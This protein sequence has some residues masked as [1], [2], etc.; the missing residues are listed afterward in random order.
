MDKSLKTWMLSQAS[1][2]LEYQQPRKSI[3]LLEALMSIDKKNPD[4]YR[5]LSYAYLKVERPEESIR[6]ADNFLKYARP[7]GDIR[8][9]KWIKGRALLKKR[10]AALSR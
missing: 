6:A 4:I 7:G 9:I 1:Y 10:K 5:M 3:A 2:Y 8:A